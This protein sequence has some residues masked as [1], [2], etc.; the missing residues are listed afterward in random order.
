MQPPAIPLLQTVE[1]INAQP[2]LPQS[3]ARL[4]ARIL[5]LPAA[6]TSGQGYVQGPAVPQAAGSP[7]PA[8]SASVLTQIPPQAFSLPG[9]GS[10]GTLSLPASPASLLSSQA[11]PSVR[12]AQLDVQLS[13]VL[14]PNVILNKITPPGEALRLPVPATLKL[15]QVILTQA[16]PA[17]LTAQVTGFTPQNLPLVTLQWPGAPLPQ[18]FV[19]QFNAGNLQLGSQIQL[20]PQN[21]T[22]AAPQ[23]LQ[24]GALPSLSNFLQSGQWPALEEVYQS[25]LQA[26]PAAAQTMARM[27]PS[28]AIP[29]QLGPAALFFI[30]AVRA[31][32]ITSWMGERKTDLL[33]RL[34]KGAL[35]N[36]LSQDISNLGRAGAEG[37]GSSS[38]WRATPLPLFWEGEIHKMALYVKQDSGNAG[39]GS[40]TADKRQTRFIF[41]LTLSRMGEVQLDGLLRGKRLDLVVRTQNAFSASMQQALRQGYAKALSDTDIYGE[42]SFQGDPRYWVR[43]LKGKE[44]LGVEA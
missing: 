7:L 14:P 36:R 26:S 41:D 13:Q 23:N 21:L 40:E 3:T 28:P 30:A 18:S 25:L 17:T 37:T 32:D 29:A 31:G 27:L 24:T 43:V 16:R 38:E 34:G 2:P 33:Q 20:Q 5:N 42:L 9:A 44:A 8:P 22:P 19:L 35:T 12:I 6:Q 4:I 39:D 1:I 10:A 15:P 11:A